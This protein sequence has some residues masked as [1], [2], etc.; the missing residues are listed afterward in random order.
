M[1]N[2]GFSK[3]KYVF[4]AIPSM[5]L[6]GSSTEEN[7]NRQIALFLKELNAY[8]VLL[9]DLVNF[10][11]RENDRNLALNVAYYLTHNEELLEIISRK[12]D[13]PI[14][15]ISKLIKIKPD[16]LTKCKDYIIAYYII[17][18]NPNY[19]GLQDLL[20]IILKEDN[21]VRSIQDK[22]QQLHKGLVIRASKKTAYIIT[23]KGEFLKIKT[24]NKV[25]IGDICEGRKKS[26][27]ANFK[28]H[29]SI[30]LLIL[31]FIGAG[32]VIEYRR[33]ESIIIIETTS[34]IKMHVN[35]FNKVI[36]TYSPT[37]KGKELINNTN[38]LNRDID[39]AVANTFEYALSNNMLDLSKK[40]LITVNGQAIK[41]GSL[42]K[43]NKVISENKIPIAINNAGNQQ[44]LPKYILED[45][46][47]TGK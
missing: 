8:N 47:D 23:S 39:D 13:L 20:K 11:I 36:Y 38:M 17:L 14:S 2:L 35:K 18:S 21:N 30:L 7:R 12:K 40:T 33:T 6:M 19:K 1:E 24:S 43:T 9:K 34:P 26:T 45:E 16:Y 42:I 44:N 15:K 10:P 29:I 32:I 46:K 5:V 3:N 22:K 25:D 41:Y 28:I 31:I 4:A 37:E 27:L